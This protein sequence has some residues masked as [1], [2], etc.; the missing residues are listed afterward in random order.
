MNSKALKVL[1]AAGVLTVTAVACTQAPTAPQAA[2]A[3]NGEAKAACLSL[4]DAGTRQD[5]GPGAT[6]W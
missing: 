3:E 5:C 1:T 2:S 4:T 6:S